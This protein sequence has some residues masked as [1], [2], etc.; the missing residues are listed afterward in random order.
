MFLVVFILTTGLIILVR[1]PP[2]HLD[3]SERIGNLH[4]FKNLL[5]DKQLYF[6][7][8]ALFSYAACEQGIS[9]WIT[10]FLDT[11]H[12]VDSQTTGSLVLSGYWMLLSLGCLIGLVLLKYIDSLKIL[13]V[14]TIAAMTCFFLSIFGGRE[15]ALWC[16]PLT[17]FF[18]SIMW[19]LILSLAMNAINR[20]HGSLSG[21]LFA[22]SSGGAFGAFMVGQLGDVFGLRYGLLFLT[23]C[24]LVVLS[25]FFRSKRKNVPENDPGFAGV[26]TG[27]IK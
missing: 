14:F 5:G 13:L 24:Y 11:Y 2:V 15:M 8:F 19:P 22:A 20:H 6:Y 25:V 3:K 12:S 16:F 23:I 1:F 4:S 9:N 7:F 18:H 26:A 17:G 27:N 10:Q 21:L